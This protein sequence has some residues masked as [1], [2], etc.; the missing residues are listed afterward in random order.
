MKIYEHVDLRPFTTFGVKAEARYMGRFASLNELKEMVS[1]RPAAGKELLVLGGGSNVLLTR[2]FPGLVLR[3]EIKGI[4]GVPYDEDR[5]LVTVGAGENWHGFVRWCI[6]K[7][8]GG[9]ENLSLIPGSVGAGPMQNIGAY[10]VEIRETF[11]ELEAF[12]IASGEIHTFSNSD[13]EFGYRESAFKGRL[14]GQY[15][16]LGV[17]FLLSKKHRLKLEYGAISAELEKMHVVEPGLDDVSQAVM[18]I[19]RSK[20]PDPAYLG[21]AGSFFKNPTLS[22]AQAE[23]ITK[24]YPDVVKYPLDAGMVKI[25]AGWLIEKAGWK[26]MRKGQCGVHVNQALVL[27]NYGGASGAEIAELS[28]AIKS[29]VRLKFGVALESEVNIL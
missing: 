13:C 26:G 18:R 27:V 11:H 20:L 1:A 2:N 22:I 17:R 7:G 15:I 21:N 28:E 10:G 25:P 23:E 29:D 19:R 3:N 5:V 8:Y 6:G 14:K 12:H 9:L 24:F 16:I 4:E